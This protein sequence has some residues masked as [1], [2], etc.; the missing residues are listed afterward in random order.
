M[1][2]ITGDPPSEDEIRL[3]CEALRSLSIDQYRSLLEEVHRLLTQ[4]ADGCV[5]DAIRAVEG[6]RQQART[7]MPQ[8]IEEVQPEASVPSKIL[9]LGGAYLQALIWALNPPLP[10]P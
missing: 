6:K 10:K 5:E 8:R 7:G 9:Y 1:R 2:E 4:E 3:L